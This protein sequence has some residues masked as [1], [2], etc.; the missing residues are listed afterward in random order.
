MIHFFLRSDNGVYALDS[1]ESLQNNDLEKLSWLF[2]SAQLVDKD[3]IKGNL[4]D[5]KKKW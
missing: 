3:H 1:N 4:L 2:G 5:Q